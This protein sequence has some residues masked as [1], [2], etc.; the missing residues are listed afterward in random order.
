MVNKYAPCKITYRS[1]SNKRA[2]KLIH[3]QTT[4][5]SNVRETAKHEAASFAQWNC[6]VIHQ[7]ASFAPT[8]FPGSLFSASLGRWKKDPGCGWS[9][10]HPESGWQKN[11]LDRKG[12]RVFCVLM[13][14][15]LWET[16]QDHLAVAKNYSFY[17]GA[18]SN[19]P[20]KDATR[21]L[22]FL[23]YRRLSFTKKFGNRMDQ[24]RFDG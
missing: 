5:F 20:M 7:A 22:P 19:L 24:K 6:D 18:K 15:T 23:K 16:N 2:I 13:W 17:H 14:Q 1:N 9:C 21:F 10:D 12:G 3:Q 4:T 8:S 11:L